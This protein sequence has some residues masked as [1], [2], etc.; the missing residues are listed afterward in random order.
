MKKIGIVG[1]LGPESTTEYY[2]GIINEFRQWIDEP[3]YPEILLYSLSL[4]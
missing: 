3:V 1:G 4:H 2:K